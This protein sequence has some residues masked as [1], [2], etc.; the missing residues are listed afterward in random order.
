MSYEREPR[1]KQIAI[2]Y[3]VL[4]N[5]L[6]SFNKPNE[7]Y[8]LPVTEEIPEGC[9]IVSL[10]VCQWNRTLTATIWHPSF[11]LVIPG[12]PIPCSPD[13]PLLF[14]SFRRKPSMLEHMVDD[15]DF[16]PILE[17]ESEA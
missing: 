11:D 5:L 16:V 14:Q 12:H 1:Y 4:I 7:F 17:A 3:S 8:G 10:D 13:S 15:D 6:N 2:S 9:D